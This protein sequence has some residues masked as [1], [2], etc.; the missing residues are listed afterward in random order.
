M[1]IQAALHHLTHYRY[2]R[3]ALLSPQVIRLRPAPHCRTPIKSYSLRITPAEHFI[4][5]QQDPQG[6]YLARV[7]FPEKVKEFKVEVD[8]VAEM[9]VINPFDFFLEEYATNYPFA[10]EA[11]LRKDLEPFLD[12]SE[13]QGEL[14]E[15]YLTR[16][17]D[18]KQH[19]VDYLVAINHDLQQDIK[20]LIRLEPGVQTPEETLAKGSGS[21]RD[22]AW[23]LVQLLR[24]LGLA[25]RFA[26]GYL[27]Q[28]TPDLKSLD[29]PS[30]TDHDF[31]DLHAWTEVFLPG[32]GWVGLDPTSG[33]LAGEG[34]IPLAC[35]AHPTSAAPISGAVEKVET[36]FSYDMK[37]SRVAEHPRVTLPYDDAAWERVNTLGREIDQRLK[38]DDVRLTMGGEPTFVSI[39]DPDGAE[40]N[41]AAVGPQ[42]R[43][44]SEILLGR[45]W[46]RFAPGGFLHYG[47]GKWYPGESLPRW[48]MTCYWRKDGQPIWKDPQWLASVD[49]DYG[50]TPD[51]AERFITALCETMGLE[52]E[53]SRAAYED[54]WYYIWKEQKLPLNVDP[55]NSKLDNAEERERLAKVFDTGLA[56]PRAYVLPLQQTWQAHAKG[57]HWISGPWL[58]RQSN[59]Y[60]LPGD[61]PVGLR[62]PL[63]TLPWVSKENYPYIYPQDP[64]A[65]LSPLP[66]ND[67]FVQQ[68]LDRARRTVEEMR[69][70]GAETGEFGPRRQPRQRRDL[71]VR[72]RDESAASQA[73]RT[74]LCAEV[75]NGQLY[76]FF[77]PVSS[78]EAYLELLAAVEATAERLEMPVFIEGEKIPKDPRINSFSVTPDPGVIE[79]N[80]HPSASWDELAERTQ[81]LYEEARLARLGT[82]KFMLDGRHTGTGGGN[83]IVIGGAITSDSPF[84]RRPDLLRSMIAYWHQHPS[85]SYLFSG[86]F[87]GP[88][89]QAPRVDEARND[90]LHELELAFREVSRAGD[91]PQ[92]WLVDRIFRN[93]LTDMTGNTHRAEFCIDKM[94]SPD[95]ASGRLGLLELRS[96]EMPPHAR[97]SLAQ[98]LL[99]RGLVSKFWR[100][101][102]NPRKLTRW[103][104]QLHDRWMLPHFVWEDF[105]E[106]LADL[107][108]DGLAFEEMWF[109][110]HREFRFPFCGSVSFMD[111]ELELRQ[112]LEPWHVLG[113]EGYAGSTV[114]FVD[115]SVERIQA[116]VQG[117]NSARYVLACNGKACPMTGTGREGEFVVGVRYRAWQ[118]PSCLHPTVGVNTPLVF[119][120]VDTW[121]GRAVAGCTY[122]VGHPGGRNYE[123][124]PVNSYEAESRRLA[125]F[126]PMGHSPGTMHGIPLPQRD[127]E[128]PC[129]LDLRIW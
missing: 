126:Q 35:S 52:A 109:H 39:D 85:L 55:L 76:I 100:N 75:R 47:Q 1:A 90:S 124:F 102:I 78:T 69:A 25:A 80:I 110:S 84:L 15:K 29:G 116:K 77:P 49:K 44:L 112:A 53:H 24:R 68:F 129:T 66:A 27:I 72:R 70:S 6:N 120:I 71:H 46:R 96:F 2:E 106:V 118:P 50:Y 12:I 23:L 51:D 34:H 7:V 83:H 3:P 121:S 95:S 114:R 16:F 30:G 99:L 26:S 94:F 86:L 43:R 64:S 18:T 13:G 87:I 98:Q 17:A 73:V 57:H 41:V 125:R 113:E 101:P 123:T 108:E 105:C 122:Y 42:K 54:I 38:D 40:W 58:T 119:D 33:L 92:P 56:T 111:M 36:Q 48:A 128:F 65:P 61:S 97:M 117:W 9:T 37:I 11:G 89:S 5:W 19:I 115:S 31:T 60:L 88:T 82:D 8:I 14:F 63:D 59:I 107:R 67:H 127:E 28:L 20:Y 10:Y 32:A 93:L 4:N 62:L 79:V 45:L 21:C 81:A 104:T 74:A 91:N 103:G 22:S